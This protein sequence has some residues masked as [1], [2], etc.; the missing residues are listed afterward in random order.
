[1]NEKK[2]TCLFEGNFSQEIDNKLTL[3][4]EENWMAE[5]ER[6]VH[7]FFSESNAV[8]PRVVYKC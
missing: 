3:K 4:E 7:I 1:M 5:G 8:T 6:D 2:Y